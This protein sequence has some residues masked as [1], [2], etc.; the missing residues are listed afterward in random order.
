MENLNKKGFVGDTVTSMAVLFGFFIVLSFALFIIFSFN[1]QMQTMDI[2][3]SAKEQQQSFTDTYP[4]MM[5]WLFPALMLG[6]FIYSVITAYL[7]EVISKVWFVIGF[8]AVFFQAIISG[9][10]QHVF[11]EIS[12]QDMFLSVLQYIPG[13]TFYFGNAILINAIWGFIILMALYFKSEG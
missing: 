12:S 4:T 2:P 3:D 5:G 8:I 13:A 1:S 6:L 10:I 11:D 7:V 9:I